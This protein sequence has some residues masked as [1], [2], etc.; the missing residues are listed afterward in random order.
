MNHYFVKT[1]IVLPVL[2]IAGNLFSQTSYNDFQKNSVKVAG[3]FS[4]MEDSVIKQFEEKKLAWPP[5][6]MYIRSFKY[7]RELEVW[8][9][10]SRLVV[11]CPTT[12]G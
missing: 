8:V 11:S 10:G 3:I 7:D 2:F 1:F 9:K 6:E 5:Q 4:S 12:C